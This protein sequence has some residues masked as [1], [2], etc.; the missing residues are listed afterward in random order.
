MRYRTNKK[1]VSEGLSH[2]I[3][4]INALRNYYTYQYF[5]FSWLAAA[6]FKARPTLLATSHPVPL[7]CS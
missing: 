5:A 2:T 6:N 3:P 7:I 4:I 1:L